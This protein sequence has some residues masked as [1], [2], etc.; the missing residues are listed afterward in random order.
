MTFL[1]PVKVLTQINLKESMVAADFGCGSGGWVIPLAKMLKNGKV[2]AIDILQ[3][4][5]SALRAKL[6]AEKLFNVDVI[7]SDV[8]KRSKLSSNSCDL[9]LMTNLLFQAEDRQGILEEAKKVLKEGGK[10]LIVDWK[11]GASIGPTDKVSAKEAQGL[12]EKVGLEFV[13][14]FDAGIY[15]WALVFTK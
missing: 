7:H 10:I 9:V 11:S 4:P 12:A 1:D 15:H 14:V 2:H 3:E 5:L 8:E 6:K 13:S